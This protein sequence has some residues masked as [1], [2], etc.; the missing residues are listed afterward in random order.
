MVCSL[1]V[2]P[3]AEHVPTVCAFNP[4]SIKLA[5]KRELSILLDTAVCEP[6]GELLPVAVA[7]TAGMSSLACCKVLTL[8]RHTCA[9]AY[10]MPIDWSWTAFQALS[11]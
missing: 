6:S 7:Y 1:S 9:C 3:N 10:A 8:P 2:R 11:R 5:V 4:L